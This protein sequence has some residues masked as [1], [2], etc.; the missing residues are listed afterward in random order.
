MKRISMMQP[1]PP[2][3]S[4]PVCCLRE[5]LPLGVPAEY[6]AFQYIHQVP[7]GMITNLTFM[8]S[9]RGMEDR[10]EEV[11]DEIS[12]IREELGYRS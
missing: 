2:F 10:L 5:G 1:S 6:D 9:Q 12:V 8:L 3:R 11:L 7:G 4:F